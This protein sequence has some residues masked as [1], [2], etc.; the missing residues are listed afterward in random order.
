MNS[1]IHLKR[2]NISHRSWIFD[3]SFWRSRRRFRCQFSLILEF[4][5]IC[6][7]ITVY[8]LIFHHILSL[9][10]TSYRV[11]WIDRIWTYFSFEILLFNHI[12]INYNKMDSV[13]A[14]LCT[15]NIANAPNLDITT[16][17]KKITIG[18]MPGCD[19]VLNDNRC[20]GNHCNITI[21][22]DTEIGGHV[23]TLTDTS[24]NG[25]YVDDQI[26]GR[27]KTHILQNGE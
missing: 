5:L 11:G 9:S 18:R 2:T 12:T 27:G 8:E 16:A 15:S 13:I 4:L 17:T 20:S 10:Y 21:L 19:I 7:K 24:T 14:R 1:D 6:I 26:L 23:F 22:E 25:T 3:F